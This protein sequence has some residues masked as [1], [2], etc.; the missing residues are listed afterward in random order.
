MVYAALG[1]LMR[2]DIHALSVDAQV[3]EQR[4]QR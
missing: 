2:T 4:E 3:P 1:S